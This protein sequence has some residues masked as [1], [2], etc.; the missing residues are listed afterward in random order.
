MV[1][2]YH[3]I[4]VE[5]RGQILQV[6]SLLPLWVLRIELRSLDLLGKLSEPLSH[7]SSPDEH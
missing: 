4:Y 7:L 1:H 5:V 3:D 6:Y 2:V